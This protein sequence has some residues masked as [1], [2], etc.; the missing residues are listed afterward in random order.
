[1]GDILLKLM[2]AELKASVSRTNPV[3]IVSS[4]LM[5]TITLLAESTYRWST[6]DTAKGQPHDTNASCGCLSKIE[7]FF[8][9]PALG[10]RGLFF[11]I[12]SP[13]WR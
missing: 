12:D 5:C 7:N 3:A 9:S 8:I 1:M 2:L 10:G 11:S 4:K 13:S 6:A